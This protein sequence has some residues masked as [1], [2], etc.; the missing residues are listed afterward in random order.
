MRKEQA[1]PAK[2]VA[3]ISVVVLLVSFMVFFPGNVIPEPTLHCVGVERATFVSRF[4]K[5]MSLVTF[6]VSNTC[7]VSVE[8]GRGVLPE[9]ILY[10]QDT[11]RAAECRRSG[12]W[13]QAEEPFAMHLN[14][15]VD[16]GR[17]QEGFLLLPAGTDFCRVRLRY[18]CGTFATKSRIGA[19]AG[20]LPMSIRSRL[21]ASFWTRFW[22]WVGFRRTEPSSNWREC[23]VDLV[24]PPSSA[25]R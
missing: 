17:T 23:V 14:C 22:R 24:L 4:G 25:S 3:T 9:A 16:P 1:L 6:C 8:P 19:L 11:G 15:T 13:V 12:V 2:A 21:P 20:H 7:Q 5:E 10:V 18:T